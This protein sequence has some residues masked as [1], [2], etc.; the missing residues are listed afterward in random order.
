M[1]KYLSEEEFE[2]IFAQAVIKSFE[3][4]LAAIPPRE[5][6]EKMYTFSNRHK[7]RMEELFEEDR[8]RDQRKNNILS[9]CQS[10][11]KKD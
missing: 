8:K 1:S 3:D 10:T 6:L 4:E 2:E 9:S 11:A 7:A 5:E